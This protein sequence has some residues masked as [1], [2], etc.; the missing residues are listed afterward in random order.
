MK[1]KCCEHA[2]GYHGYNIKKMMESK[3]TSP[4]KVDECDC[5]DFIGDELKYSHSSRSKS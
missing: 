4:C 5:E 1:C 2:S 3:Y